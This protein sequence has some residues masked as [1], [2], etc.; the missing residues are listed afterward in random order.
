MAP[1]SLSPTKQRARLFS[2]ARAFRV[3]RDLYGNQITTAVF[4]LAGT[5]KLSSSFPHSP[6]RHIWWCE[7]PRCHSRDSFPILLKDMGYSLFLGRFLFRYKLRFLSLQKSWH[8]GIQTEPMSVLYPAYRCCFLS[9]SL[10]PDRH[11]S[12]SSG[13]NG[14]FEQRDSSAGSMMNACHFDE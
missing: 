4:G 14:A 7:F 8:V 11:L 1:N 3:V 9:T 5:F 10:T 12:Y 13:Q 2:L 6:V